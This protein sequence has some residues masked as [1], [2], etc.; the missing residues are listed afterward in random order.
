M[1]AADIETNK[2]GGAPHAKQ[3]LK[4]GPKITHACSLVQSRS[5]LTSRF[6]LSPTAA[7]TAV[8][9]AAEFE[10]RGEHRC[11]VDARGAGRG[12][13]PVWGLPRG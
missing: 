4:S 5:V 13:P 2:R 8:A 9:A 1:R 10:E 7:A 12:G 6:T 3:A 11:A